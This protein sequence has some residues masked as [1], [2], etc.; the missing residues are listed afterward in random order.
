M[1][2]YVVVLGK[3]G[4]YFRASSLFDLNVSKL[5]GC[6]RDNTVQ[7]FDVVYDQEPSHIRSTIFVRRNVRVI[8]CLPD[9]RFESGLDGMI[10]R[11]RS[12]AAMF[13]KKTINRGIYSVPYD[14]LI[15]MVK[16]IH[17]TLQNKQEMAIHSAESNER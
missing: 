14:E 10:F 12:V 4:V 9:G 15:R 13:Y 17:R 5:Y 16:S 6:Y 3:L 2:E 1:P 8:T 7:E 11:D